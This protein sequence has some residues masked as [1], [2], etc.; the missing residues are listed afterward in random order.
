MRYYVPSLGMATDTGI[1]TADQRENLQGESQHDETERRYVRE[2]V[3]NAIARDALVLWEN[4]QPDDRR[5]VFRS[6][7]HGSVDRSADAD[8]DRKEDR[9][10]ALPVGSGAAALL[11]F[12]Y[13]GL[14]EP[15]TDR[16]TEGFEATLGNAMERV[17]RRNGWTLDEFEF[18]VEFDR[19]RD[20]EQLRRRFNEGT[21]T[22]EE[23]TELL[24]HDVITNAEYAGY[25][26]TR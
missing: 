13:L 26:Q 10:E 25:A 24:R 20:F 1:L 11:A 22:I 9:R 3:R 5:W 15:N 8:E 7:D 23:A 6:T 12:L 4:L 16:Q 2:Q 17:A 19:D 21:A 18:T 14:E